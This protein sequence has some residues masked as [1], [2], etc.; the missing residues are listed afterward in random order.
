LLTFPVVVCFQAKTGPS[1]GDDSD[2]WAFN[3]EQKPRRK[4]KTAMTENA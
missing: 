3:G 2:V 4:T 1:Q